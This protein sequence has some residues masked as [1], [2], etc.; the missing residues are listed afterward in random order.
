MYLSRLSELWARHRGC[1]PTHAY[2][3]FSGKPTLWKSSLQRHKSLL[4]LPFYQWRGTSQR[5]WSWARSRARRC[6]KPG[7]TGAFYPPAKTFCPGVCRGCLPPWDLSAA[8]PAPTPSTSL[9]RFDWSSR[10]GWRSPVWSRRAGR[11]SSS[12]CPER[13]LDA[14]VPPSLFAAPRPA[15]PGPLSLSDLVGENIIWKE[16]G[17]PR[18]AHA[19]RTSKSQS[20]QHGPDTWLY[21]YMCTARRASTHWCYLRTCI[22][23]CQRRECVST[24]QSRGVCLSVQFVKQSAL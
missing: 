8:S 19:R 11:S 1:P 20:W 23:T 24:P 4:H 15:C 7:R 6:P 3:S 13:R 16:L 21:P 22:Y 14:P 2:S 12:P 17:H 9:R 10:R 5:G 18:H